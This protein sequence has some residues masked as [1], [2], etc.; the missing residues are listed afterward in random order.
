MFEYLAPFRVV[1]VTGPARSGT[2][3]CG[4]MIAADTGNTY[5]DDRTEI[6]SIGKL[7]HVVTSESNA[8]A[9][10]PLLSWHVDEF[11]VLDDVAVVMVRRNIVEINASND[12]LAP[13]RLD[14]W[15]DGYHALYWQRG[16]HISEA[17]YQHWDNVQRSRIRHPYDVQYA[18]LAEHPLWVP[19]EQRDYALSWGLK[20]WGM[21]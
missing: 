16:R 1:I 3:I 6:N 17:V 2:T 15:R 7:R 8:V 20:T 4:H 9:Q 13:H 21:P 5:M 18:A 12:R 19:V 14:Y 10:C 11:G